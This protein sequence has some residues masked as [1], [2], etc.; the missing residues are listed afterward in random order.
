MSTGLFVFGR[1]KVNRLLGDGAERGSAASSSPAGGG[2]SRPRATTV[3]PYLRAAAPSGPI[4]GL[5]LGG[6]VEARAHRHSTF[7]RKDLVRSSFG[8]AK[9]SMGGALSTIKPPSVK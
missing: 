3:A 2:E 7:D 4:R 9:N 1:D 5:S 6:L 8:L